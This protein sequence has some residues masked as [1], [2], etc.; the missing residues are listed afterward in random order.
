MR[1]LLAITLL[2]SI[3]LFAAFA[4]VSAADWETYY[5]KS[6]FKQTPRY[7]ETI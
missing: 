2:I 5:E 4:L 3:S 7:K 6:G 1:R